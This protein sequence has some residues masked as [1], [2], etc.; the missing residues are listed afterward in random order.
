MGRVLASLTIM[1]GLAAMLWLGTGCDEG[2]GLDGLTVTPNAV[3]LS[4]VY[5]VV[6]TA[7]IKGSLALPLEWRVSNP[8]IG[9]IQASSGS[10][11]VYEAFRQSSPDS[12]GVYAL[13]PGANVI[14]ARDQYGNEG[15]AGV[16]QR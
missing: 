16:T 11:A 10:N 12:N 13:L 5:T 2:D 7:S 4:N 15:S 8:D 3:T 1:A 14:T 6:F 9:V